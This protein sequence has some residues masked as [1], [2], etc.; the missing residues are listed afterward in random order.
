MKT[1]LNWNKDYTWQGVDLLNYKEQDRLFE[2]VTRQVLFEG[3]AELPCQWRYFEVAPGG[4]STLE[5]HVHLHVVMVLRGR[6]QVLLGAAIHEV[7]AF[8]LLRIPTLTWHQFRAT[9]GE[10][11][12]F[13]CLVNQERDKPQLPGPLDLVALGSTPEVA[14]FIRV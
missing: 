5:R 8:D 13:L 10:P 1:I 7:R 3:A 9:R 2:G 14:D 12:G 4:H 11:L 6:G